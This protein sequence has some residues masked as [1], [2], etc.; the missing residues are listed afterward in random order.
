[1]PIIMSGG[2]VL[3][4]RP[5]VLKV[6]ITNNGLSPW[7]VVLVVNIVTIAFCL[8]VILFTGYNF[9]FNFALNITCV[10]IIVHQM[11][12]LLRVDGR[13]YPAGALLALGRDKRREH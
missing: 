10:E 6:G 2:T 5:K 8:F 11:V 1:M 13:Q 7:T 3:L 9:L 12:G 4:V